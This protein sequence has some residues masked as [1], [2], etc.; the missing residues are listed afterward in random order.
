M[1]FYFPMREFPE[2]EISVK[3]FA[4]EARADAFKK[5]ISP[6]TKTTE[7]EPTP[8]LILP[9]IWLTTL[10]RVVPRKEAPFPQI[11]IIPKYSPDFSG[12]IILAK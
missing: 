7:I 9:E 12:G 11:S 3:D 10:T 5:Q 2:T 6:M 1:S 4:S 8:M